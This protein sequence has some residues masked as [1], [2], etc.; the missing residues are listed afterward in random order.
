MIELVGGILLILGLLTPLVAVLVVV[1]MIGAFFT[2]HLGSGV[3]VSDNGR[4]LIAVVGLAA[5]VFV[6]VG[7][8][9]YSVDAVLARGRADRA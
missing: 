8:G 2:V 6:L 9:R 4:E 7:P 1:V 3:H 5:A